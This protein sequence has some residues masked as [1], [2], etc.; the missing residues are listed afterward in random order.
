[1]KLVYVYA[2]FCLFGHVTEIE[3]SVR[4]ELK[5]HGGVATP[6][7]ANASEKLTTKHRPQHTSG[8]FGR[9]SSQCTLRCYCGT[10]FLDL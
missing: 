3:S 4:A 9:L 2:A 1:M 7:R 10:G 5:L 8:A 6:S